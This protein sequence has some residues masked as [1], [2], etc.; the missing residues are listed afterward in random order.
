MSK[1]AVVKPPAQLFDLLLELLLAQDMPQPLVASR[2]KPFIQA[3]R[4]V[5]EQLGRTY[6]ILQGAGFQLT[7]TFEKPSFRL[8]QVTA[9]LAPEVFAHM[10]EHA[11][12]LTPG[13]EVA[14]SWKNQWL[15]LWPKLTVQPHSNPQNGVSARFMG[16]LPAQK[17][18]V[19]TRL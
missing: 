7:A 5:P 17:F 19:L 8:Y 18:I 11:Q 14:V 3:S 1:N 6:L 10:K 2:L 12:A 13:P 9:R 16:W 15:G 4:L